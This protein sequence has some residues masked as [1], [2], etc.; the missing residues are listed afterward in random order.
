MPTISRFYG[1]VITM[2]FN[3]HPPPH[4]HVRYGEHLGRVA[5]RTGEVLTG[6]L[7]SRVVRLVVEWAA[8]HSDELDLNWANARAKLPLNPV[9]PLP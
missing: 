1:I 2:Y 8:L 7:P 9:D 6:D 5:Y 4:V 3:D